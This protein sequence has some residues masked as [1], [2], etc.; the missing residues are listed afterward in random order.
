MSVPSPS[1]T[2]TAVVTGASSGIGE[3]F[4]RALS[5]RGHH[6]SLVARSG[7]R[8]RALAEELGNA[9]ALPADL[10]DAGAREALAGAIEGAGRSVE[11]LVNCAGF[12]VYEPFHESAQE[13]ELQQVR[14]LTEAPMELMHRWLPGMIERGRGAIINVSSTSAFQALPY[15]AGYAAAKSYLLLLSEAVHAE[16]RDLGI[17]VTAVCPGPVRTAFQEAN[18]ARFAE[19]LPKLVWVPAA[20]VAEESLAA[21]G[22]NERVVVPG[23]PLVRAAFAAN[24]FTPR[25]L[26]LAISKRVMSQ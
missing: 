10:S 7:E 12:G 22:R 5:A 4:A 13:L 14:L 9:S 19:K 25:G 16:V 6:V 15:N 24:R 23:G 26:T 2:S 20:R 8:L 1:E 3:Q 21:A 18:D 11:I 17:S